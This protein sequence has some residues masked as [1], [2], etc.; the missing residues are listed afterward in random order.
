MYNEKKRDDVRNCRWLK[1]SFSLPVGENLCSY[2]NIV[3][4]IWDVMVCKVINENTTCLTRSLWSWYISTADPDIIPGT[5][6][7][8]SPIPHKTSCA[9]LCCCVS[10]QSWWGILLSHFTLSLLLTIWQLNSRP[11]I[12]IPET[13]SHIPPDLTHFI[14]ICGTRQFSLQTECRQDQEGSFY[15]MQ[16]EFYYYPEQ[17]FKFQVSCGVF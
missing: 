17:K 9:D 16:E 6:P 15:N 8:Y 5:I 1:A 14:H 3:A 12:T 7:V 10:A 4:H 2:A 13:E 11:V